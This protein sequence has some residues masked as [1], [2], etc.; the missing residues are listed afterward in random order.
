MGK[1]W[2]SSYP[3][4]VESSELVVVQDSGSVLA[5]LSSFVKGLVSG[6]TVGGTYNDFWVL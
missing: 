6:F 2:G 3:Q 4:I 1:S 5:R